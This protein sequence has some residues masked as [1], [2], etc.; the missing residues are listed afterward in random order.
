MKNAIESIQLNTKEFLI[1]G[2]GKITNYQEANVLISNLSNIDT[3][4]RNQDDF[5]TLL[6][7]L[8]PTS[9]ICEKTDR[10]E[11]GDFQTPSL[12]TNSIC[13]YIVNGGISPDILIEPTFG[14]GSFIISALEHFPRLKAVYGIEIN[15]SYYWQTKFAI[16]ELF[17]NEPSTNKPR[18]FLYL[19]TIFNFDLGIISKSIGDNSVLIL[20]NPPWVT[21]SELGRLNS[22]NLPK[23]SNLKFLNGLDAITGKG[24]FDIAEYII[25]MMLDSFSKYNGYMAI[26]IKNSII[27]NL[28]YDL[29]RT[30]YTINN[31]TALSIDAKRS[32]NA[33]VE[34]SLFK[35]DFEH[36]SSPL[37]CKVSSLTSPFLVENEFG[38]VNDK[39]VSDVVLYEKT[40]NYDGDC[41]YIWRQGIKHD[42]SK[43]MELDFVNNKYVN[44]LKEELDI[45]NEPIYGLI[46]SSDLGSLVIEKPR[47]YV[48][49]TQ[50]RV[51]EDTS[52]LQKKYPKLYQYLTENNELFD[53]RKS[54]I[55]NDKPPFSI[56]GIGNYSFKPYKV[57][58][59]GLYKRSQFS[60]IFP[61]DIKPIM[62][63]DTCYFLGFDDISEAIFVWAILNSDQ[64]QQF[65]KSI[66]FIDAKRPYTKDILMRIDIDKVAQ[67]FTYS[68]I[69]DQIN[70][71]DKRLLTNII[72]DKWYEFIE[73]V[74]TEKSEN[75]QLSLFEIE[76]GTS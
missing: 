32:F 28:I 54:S 75:K 38:W 45:E 22:N 17:I 40:M 36:S 48:I 20:G 11:Y 55:Y 53:K 67:E 50:E 30:N 71:L 29:P 19:D 13:S 41:P 3:F 60:L 46:K 73:K 72:D 64:I 18:I 66:V 43:I 37:I 12:L 74:N 24:N 1:D 47:K 44:G 14:K 39:F 51:G 26:L 31:L 34:A 76:N 59:S 6:E 21:N 61:D 42:C 69:I 56:F 9:V 33:S 70:S 63:D 7:L 68:E 62:L 8:K 5:S 57:S 58:I 52:H 49:V 2:I 65:L 16:L 15:E 10:R 23:K 27:R 4:F 35:C 25:L